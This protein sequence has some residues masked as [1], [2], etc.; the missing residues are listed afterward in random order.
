M[1]QEKIKS[2]PSADLHFQWQMKWM[3]KSVKFIEVEC[4]SSALIRKGSIPREQFRDIFTFYVIKFQ[5]IYEIGI[6]LENITNCKKGK[7][8]EE[9]CP[10]TKLDSP[11]WKIKGKE[12]KELA[13]ELR[14]HRQVRKFR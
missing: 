9:N 8:S 10:S 13:N 1:R 2:F 7:G 5:V 4:F 14:L 6:L 11:R 12:G 3:K